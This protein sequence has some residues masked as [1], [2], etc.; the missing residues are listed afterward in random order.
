MIDLDMVTKLFMIDPVA[1]VI[2]FM[3]YLNTRTVKREIVEVKSRLALL[4][5]HTHGGKTN[6]LSTA[7]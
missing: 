3:I 5:E 7:T 1:C 2:I 4:E 6:E